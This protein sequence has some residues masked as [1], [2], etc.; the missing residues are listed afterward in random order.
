MA[1]ALEVLSTFRG[2]MFADATPER[3]FEALRRGVV[4]ATN[5]LRNAVLER[6]PGSQRGFGVNT[7]ILRKSIAG[8][9]R[10]DLTGRTIEGVVGSPLI[11]APVIEDG[12][13]PGTYPPLDAI[14]LWVNQKLIRG[15]DVKISKGGGT[16]ALGSAIYIE[17]MARQ[18]QR[19]IHDRGFAPPYNK[20]LRMFANAAKYAASDVEAAIAQGVEL[21]RQTWNGAE[22]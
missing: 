9:T 5:A 22:A 19:N 20:G 7:G 17:A 12:R 14:K 11:Y 1:G 21:Y 18:I 8:E 10:A 15:G 16:S 3:A 2:P 4:L 13:S 6:M